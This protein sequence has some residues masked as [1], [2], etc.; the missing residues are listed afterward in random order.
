M[1]NLKFIIKVSFADF[2]RNKSRTFLT[3]LGIL[4][5]VM[6]VVLLMALGLGLKKYI[7]NQFESLG[8]NLVYVIPGN[9]KALLKGGGMIG[10]IKF[11]DKDV[12][13]LRRIKTIQ[14][15]AP[16][17]AKSGATIQANG[18]KEIVEILASNEE[19]ISIMNLELETGRLIGKKDLQKGNK[20]IMLHSTMAEK[21]FGKA[22]NALGKNVVIE[23]QNFKVIGILKSKGGGG[24]GGGSLDDHVYITTKSAYFMNSDKK[25]YGIYFKAVDKESVP[26]TK[27]EAEQILVKRYDKDDFSVME[28]TELM[29]TISSIF[30]VI[31]IVLVAIAA[32][33]LV[34]G[35]IGIMNIMYVTVTERIKE[36]GIRRALGAKK[37][38]ILYQFLSESVLLSVI[39]GFLGLVVSFIIVLLVQSIFPAYINLFS[40]LL[41]L[42]VSS[43]IGIIFGVFP[44][45]RAANLSPIEAIRYE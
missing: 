12:N 3:S 7:E 29:E 36:I 32:I 40:V 25:Y 2:K 13:N 9:K 24:F 19:I 4:I 17:F 10:G 26:A 21:L 20:I 16:V 31:N 44:A 28:Q 35:G 34:V 43:L 39:G 37:S 11:D 14:N 38:D 33:S 23:K 22:A 27:I 6:A 41:A 30:A 8:A 5:G 15:I 42:G 18:K 1:E 45:K